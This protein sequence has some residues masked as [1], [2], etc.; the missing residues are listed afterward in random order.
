MCACSP[1]SQSCPGLQKK[2]HDQQLKGTSIPLL[3]PQDTPPGVLCPALGSS[4][5]TWTWCCGSWGGHRDDQ[6]AGAPLLQGAYEERLEFFR[7]RERRLQGNLFCSLLVLKENY[8]RHG[9]KL[10][11][12]ACSNRMGSNGFKGNECQSRL[13]T[14]KKFLTIGW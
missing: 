14:R 4:G 9:D 12:R 3:C 6:R 5:K 7:L 8:K 11:I 13:H 1:E 10:F 2:K